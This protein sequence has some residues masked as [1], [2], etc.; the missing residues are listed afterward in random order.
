MRTLASR[1][2]LIKY[3]S[4]TGLNWMQVTVAKKGTHCNQLISEKVPVY[5]ISTSL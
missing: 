2:P 3:L 4:S 5:V 1:D